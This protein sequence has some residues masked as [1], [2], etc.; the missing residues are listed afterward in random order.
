MIVTVTLNPALDKTVSLDTLMPGKLNRIK[1]VTVDA[2][3]KGVN[4][5]KMANVLGVDCV[6]TGFC[7]G[8]NGKLLLDKLDSLGIKHDFVN[9]SSNT[10]TNTKVFDKTYGIT[11]LNESGAEVSKEEQQLLFEKLM[12]YAGDDTIFVLSGS[13]HINA[14]K[15]YYS[16]LITE[17]KS[18]NQ[19]V[20]FDADGEA[21]KNAVSKIPNFIKPNDHELLGYL[22]KQ[23]MNQNEMFDACKD[24]VKSG[25][26]L[27]A[28]SLGANGA[29]FFSKEEA[30][31]VE[32]IDVEVLSTVGAGDSMVAAAACAKQ[33]GLSFLE[34]AKLAVAASAGAVTTEGTKPPT[35]ELVEQLKKQAVVKPL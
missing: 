22:G 25:I 34:T 11:E 18:K 17:L 14:T 19:T 27:V 13:T 6:A 29:A 10:R 33:M 1:S 35:A 9:V 28:L 23:T 21:F 26:E 32:A 8:E 15:N 20:F 16:E 31:F 2:G 30:C 7:G 12:S 3:G 24:F 5:A 4:V